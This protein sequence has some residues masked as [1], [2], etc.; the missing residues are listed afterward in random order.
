MAN[1]DDYYAKLLGGEGAVAGGTTSTAAAGGGLL[2]KLK[3]GGKGL[4][5]MKGIG[6]QLLGFMV[7]NKLLES[8]NQSADRGVQREGMRAQAEMATPENLYYQAAQPRAEEEEAQARSALLTQ[9]SGGV[10]G[11]ALPRGIRRIG[12][13]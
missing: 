1:T 11:P 10:L 3:A 12:G 8:R 7:L 6:A 4:K 5:G 9:I 2:G 13:R